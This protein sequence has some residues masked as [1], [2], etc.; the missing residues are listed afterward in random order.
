MDMFSGAAEELMEKPDFSGLDKSGFG[1]NSLFWIHHCYQFS[2]GKDI[3]S[4]RFGT[5]EN[6]REKKVQHRVFAHCWCDVWLRAEDIV[7]SEKLQL[8]KP[9]L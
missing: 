2:D 1:S 8:P 6:D 9:R 7:L 3:K 5:A 4:F